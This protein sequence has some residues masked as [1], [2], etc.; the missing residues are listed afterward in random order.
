[1]SNILNL[2]LFGEI[3]TESVKPIIEKIIETDTMQTKTV[4]T[5]NLYINSE[6]GSVPDAFGLVDIILNSNTVIN[7]YCVGLCCS[8]ATLVYLAGNRRYAYEHSTFV[9]HNISSDIQ[10]MKRRD[11][12]EYNKWL[13]VLEEWELKLYDNTTENMWLLDIINEDKERRLTTEQALELEIVTD[14][15]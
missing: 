4:N 8:A 9:F 1:M 11:L 5:I 10:D 2:F 6:G 12:E 15:I 14:M 7:T 13:A 3:T